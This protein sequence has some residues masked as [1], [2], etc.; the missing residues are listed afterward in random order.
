[1]SEPLPVDVEIDPR[2]GAWAVHGVQ[3]VLVPRHLITGV[4][5]AA[6]QQVGFADARG[7]ADAA[8]YAAAHEWCARQA[9][10][11][12]LHG[13]ALVH[14]YVEQLSGRGWGRFS[15]VALDLDSRY[16]D[17]R[18][19]NSALADRGDG[20]DGPTCYP[21]A[22]WLAGAV[23]YAAGRPTEGCSAGGVEEAQCI[24]AGASHCRLVSRSR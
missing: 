1:M 21:F 19:D 9:V 17:V 15:V 16:I 20:A 6:E 24:N 22:S 14:H 2:S 10:Y 3:M 12:S 23:D 18:V 7:V 11:H 5:A 4:L 13:D 8:G